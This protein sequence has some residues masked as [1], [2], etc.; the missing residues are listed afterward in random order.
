[1]RIVYAVTC[2]VGIAYAM[3]LFRNLFPQEDKDRAHGTRYVNDE[4][5]SAT[6]ETL[7]FPLYFLISTLLIIGVVDIG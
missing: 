7:C 3:T 1:M 4:T 2:R 5:K 6:E